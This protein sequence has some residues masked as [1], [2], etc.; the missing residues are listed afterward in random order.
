VHIDVLIGLILV[1]DVVN[2]DLELGKDGC[3]HHG[4]DGIHWLET[5]GQT[6]RRYGTLGFAFRGFGFWITDVVFLYLG[7]S[8]LIL[9]GMQMGMKFVF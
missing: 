6:R 8:D 2:G 3:S 7:K 9:N 4:R 1:L 5:S